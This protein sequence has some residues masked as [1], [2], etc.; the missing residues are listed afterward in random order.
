MKTTITI[1][2]QPSGNRT[3]LHAIQTSDSEVEE[4][5][6][7]FVITFGSKKE[8]KEAISNA[9]ESLVH[10]E[11]DFAEDGISFNEHLSKLWYDASVACLDK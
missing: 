11:P 4:S 8:A 10:E 6:N 3:L 9:Y 1:T 2:G 5:F 7:N